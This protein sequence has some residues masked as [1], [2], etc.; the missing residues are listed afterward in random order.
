ML[1]KY[2]W[3]G[4]PGDTVADRFNVP[5]HSAGNFLTAIAGH[6]AGDD[7]SVS[8]NIRQRLRRKTQKAH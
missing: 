1:R 7:G 6:R 8:I 5:R 2:L 3:P 4:Q